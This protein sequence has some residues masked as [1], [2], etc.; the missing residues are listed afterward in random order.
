[1]CLQ[2]RQKSALISHSYLMHQNS[3][4]QASKVSVTTDHIIKWHHTTSRHDTSVPT[5]HGYIH[6]L[7]KNF[8]HFRPGAIFHTSAG[9]ISIF[10]TSTGRFIQTLIQPDNHAV[11]SWL[12]ISCFENVSYTSY[13]TMTTL[14]LWSLLRRAHSDFITIIIIT[15]TIPV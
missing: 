9:L 15:I 14:R 6:N 1:M 10:E 2:Y 3:A 8:V 13:A 12:F 5:K 4:S 7:S 11:L